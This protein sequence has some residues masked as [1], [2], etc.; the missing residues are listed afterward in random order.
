M[1]VDKNIQK[2]AN[3]IRT[4][5]YGSEVRESLASGLEEMSADVVENES[6]QTNVEGQF[7][8]VLDETTGKDVISAPEITASRVGADGT[9]H[10][11]L[12]QR[13]DAEQQEVT[14]Q[15]AEKANIEDLEE[16]NTVLNTELSKKRDKATKIKSSDLDVS[17]N[18]HKIKPINVS[19]ELMTMFSP[20]G[21]SNPIIA[22]N[23]ITKEKYADGSLSI[24]K[25][26]DTV[27]LNNYPFHD[28]ATFSQN[29]D[30]TVGI[31]NGILDLVLYGAD[32]NKEYRVASLNRYETTAR[33][34]N[35]VIKDNDDIEVARFVHTNY[36]EPVGVDIVELLERNS[37]G[38][39]GK[40]VVDWNKLDNNTRINNG[41][42]EQFGL[43]KKTYIKELNT[44]DTQKI[45]D[46]AI[47]AEKLSDFIGYDVYPFARKSKVNSNKERAIDILAA[48]KDIKLY[49]VDVDK[50]LHI[51]SLYCDF[52]STSS[53]IYT[54]ELVIS[55]AGGNRI[56]RY[57][58][59][60]PQQMASGLKKYDLS[61]LDNSGVSGVLYA[62]FSKLEKQVLLG[63]DF[64]YTGLDD[65]VKFRVVENEVNHETSVDN[66]RGLPEYH[67][68]NIKMSISKINNNQ[69]Y[70]SLSFGI[71]TDS[72]ILSTW[73]SQIAESIL[74]ISHLTEYADL[75][76]IAHLGDFIIGDLPKDESLTLI[77]DSV[78]WS[79]V[80]AKKPVFTVRGNHDDNAV[81]QDFDNMTLEEQRNTIITDEEFYK[82]AIRR[83]NKY[84][85]VTDEE[86]PYGG[87]YYKDFPEQKIRAIFCNTT[88]T[89]YE[90]N[91]EMSVFPEHVFVGV[92]SNAQIKWLV[93]KALV[94]DEEWAVMMFSHIPPF[95]NES[96]HNRGTD[97]P[98]FRQL[99]VDF[100]NGSSGVVT[101]TKKSKIGD[102]IPVPYDFTNQGSREFIGHF[103]GHV[104]EDSHN[105]IDGINYFVSNCTTP[106]KRWNTSPEREPAGLKTL[107]HN[108]IIVDRNSKT[109][110]VVKTGT[111]DDWEFNW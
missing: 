31:Q 4:K 68:E 30:E 105:V 38:I 60:E 100:M 16:T 95:A 90:E 43:D 47:T 54:T 96:I 39:T 70:N 7:Q 14:A 94:V 84:G 82:V 64:E 75:D 62:D 45:N 3:D 98:E 66:V 103:L 29:E 27:R 36:P 32:E 23:S 24:N 49:N 48:I 72:H 85:I 81:N 46:E 57:R 61:E 50:K 28:R 97:R 104:H 18:E 102:S 13:L 108:N 12:K 76:F 22:D 52:Y 110:K 10:A 25:T 37:S 34:N 89:S 17:S 40:L 73:Y 77:E 53:Q 19:D 69:T 41:T 88:Q 63:G 101:G 51:S 79:E 91:G 111:G 80:Y 87:Y 42:F 86:S 8:A 78:Y 93:E 11:N 21:S 33:Q 99:C 107:S 92:Y 1:A 5:Q 26:N 67:N 83:A 58:V 9:Q 2:K 55:D 109:V 44:I 20:A 106:S 56:C 59:N 65:K 35:I 74:A 6:R 71:I 15:L